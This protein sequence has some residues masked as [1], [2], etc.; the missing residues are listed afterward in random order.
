MQTSKSL[1]P[2]TEPTHTRAARSSW[3]RAYL[4]F[5]ISRDESALLKVA[6][7]ALVGIL[8]LDVLSNIVP[9]VGEL[10]DIGYI[11]ALAVIIART[12]SRVRKYR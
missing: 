1:V 2:I 12:L 3:S 9:I 5:L 6:P 7:L 10:D 4:R 8:P 11:I